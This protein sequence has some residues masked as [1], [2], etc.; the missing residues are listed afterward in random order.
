LRHW[1]ILDTDKGYEL[2]YP[3]AYHLTFKDPAA[4]LIKPPVDA[5][6]EIV[7]M[8][9]RLKDIP[10]GAKEVGTT[11]F[12][13]AQLMEIGDTIIKAFGSY[14]R[15]PTLYSTLPSCHYEWKRTV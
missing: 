2:K 8:M 9:N 4:A 14:H 10:E 5:S 6:G 15:V 1:A 7:F 12:S 11:R 13:H 3:R